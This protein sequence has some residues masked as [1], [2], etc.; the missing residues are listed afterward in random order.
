VGMPI[1]RGA[2][3][4]G[5]PQDFNRFEDCIE[6]GLCIS[7]CPVMLTNP[8][9]LGPAGLASAER[10]VVE[11]R[12]ADIPSILHLVDDENGCWRCHTAFECSEVC[13]S[14]VDPAAAIMALRRRLIME[15]IKSLFGRGALAR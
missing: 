8:Q 4:L 15:R 3:P 13:P 11:P 9:Y 2:E 6:C 14:N 5:E 10:L 12:G 1:V 7:A